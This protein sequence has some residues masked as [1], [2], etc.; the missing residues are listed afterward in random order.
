[1]KFMKRVVVLSTMVLSLCAF[2]VYADEEKPTASADIS[3]LSK[4]IWRGYELSDD[5]IVIQPSVT[6]V[7]KGFS[8][9][10]WGNLDTSVD[11]GD[12]TTDD[13][14]D[15]TETDLTLSYKRSFGPV[16]LGAGF[17]YYSLNGPDT[18]EIYGS[19]GL[20]VLLSPTITVYKDIAEFNGWYIKLGISH[21]FALPK[22]ISLDLS[23]GI[24]YYY[25]TDDEF[26]EFNDQL[27]VTT[28]RY[29]ALHDG[30]L[31]A[32]LA[33]PLN[34][35]LTLTPSLTYSFPLS[36]DADN[37]LTATSFSGRSD[38]LYGGI[39]LTLAF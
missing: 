25:S 12:P 1:M 20:N 23:G 9:N 18:E 24:G 11:D 29:K 5:S 15:L 19:V 28:N 3:V 22:D 8:M 33:I 7:Y 10:V 30:V 14:S 32:G 35:H 13:D 34:K 39:T 17:I 27:V 37:L 2:S 21:S 4:Y 31:S 16:N 36:G 6:V 38:F 26:V